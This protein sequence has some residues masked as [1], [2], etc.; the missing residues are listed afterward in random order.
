MTGVEK[1]KK[2]D[3]L[4]KIVNDI[5]AE[6]HIKVSEFAKANAALYGIRVLDD[7]TVAEDI[8]DFQVS[9]FI[10][11]YL[12]DYDPASFDPADPFDTDFPTLIPYDD[13]D[14]GDLP[15]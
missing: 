11:E 13:E 1:E 4:I 6:E 12:L 2:Y 5:C 15:Y 14:D 3:E 7:P 10:R 8:E 9:D